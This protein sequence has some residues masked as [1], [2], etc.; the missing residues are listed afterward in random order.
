MLLLGAIGGVQLPGTLHTPVKSTQR[1][2]LMPAQDCAVH[3]VPNPRNVPPAAL[4]CEGVS[5]VQLG[6]PLAPQQAPVVGQ[7]LPGV[8]MMIDQLNSVPVSTV[9]SS[10]ITRVHAPDA[11]M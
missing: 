9:A 1:L 10:V 3:S 11:G 4:H 7:G 6:L 5:T 8:P 2:Q